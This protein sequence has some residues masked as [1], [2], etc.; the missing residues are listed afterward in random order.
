MTTRKSPFG[1]AMKRYRERWG[2]A[3]PGYVRSRVPRGKTRLEFYYLPVW[4][5]NWEFLAEHL[6]SRVRGRCVSCR[7]PA[8]FHKMDCHTR[9]TLADDLRRVGLWPRKK[10]DLP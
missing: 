1:D 6:W 9:P 2:D 10:V 5:D 3:E 4:A 7:M 8:P